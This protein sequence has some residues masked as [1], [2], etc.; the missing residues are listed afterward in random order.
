MVARA[1]NLVHACVDLG[2]FI[3][4]LGLQVIID[5]FTDPGGNEKV[6]VAE[7][8]HLA[9]RCTVAKLPA[10]TT[11]EQA[12]LA[13]LVR[14][15]VGEPELLGSMNDLA[16]T[17]YMHHQSPTNCGRVID[18]LRIAVA[19]NLDAKHGWPI[20]RNVVN[21]NV[22]EAYLKL[23]SEHSKVTR[24]GDRRK[25]IPEAEVTEITARTWTIMNRFLAYRL[26][27]NQPLDS[28]LYPALVG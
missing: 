22:D 10:V 15:I 5:R 16:M 13:N 2:A 24:H 4:G 25:S 7:S 21:V 18:S 19:P 1:S 28:A 8:P 14:V 27:G 26:G 6:I 17:L 3:S 20:L 11:E 9:K 23:I 12:N